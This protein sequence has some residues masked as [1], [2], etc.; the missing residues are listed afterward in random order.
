MEES[1]IRTRRGA[2]TAE[3]LRVAAR[4]V[5]AEHGYA[6]ARVEDVVAAAGVSHGT[7]YTYYD[8]KAAVLDA[9]VDDTAEALAAVAAE[10][11]D[12]E[13][14]T[15]TVE[16]VLSRFVEVFIGEADVIRTWLEASALEPEFRQR[17]KAVR[18]GYI[19]RVAEQLAPVTET[20]EHDAQVAAGALVAMV[21]GY[22][23][24]RFDSVAGE[25]R[26]AAVR[27]LAAIWSG[28]I[29]QLGDG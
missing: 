2:A 21:E 8:N 13:D 25:E 23:T 4:E 3:R 9:L 1:T 29:R 20:T 28:G 5:F 24:A 18:R 19:E 26:A 10:P 15:A 22:A 27:T 12:G 16:D 14:V 7:F 17:L 6:A 11:W